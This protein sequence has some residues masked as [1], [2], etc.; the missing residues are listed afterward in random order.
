M[1]SRLTDTPMTNF[2]SEFAAQMDVGTDEA[3]ELARQLRSA[4][5]AADD[6]VLDHLELLLAVSFNARL[7]EASNDARFL[8]LKFLLRN[9]SSRAVRIANSWV[10]N[11][12]SFD[13]MLAAV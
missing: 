11:Q 3:R 4:P 7:R 1:P 8:K 6:D 10:E 5:V 2:L 9:N 13:E 12:I